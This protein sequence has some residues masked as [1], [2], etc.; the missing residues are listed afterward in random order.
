MDRPTERRSELR[1]KTN[2]PI[3]FR[4][5]H[6]LEYYRAKELNHSND[7]LSFSVDI[8]LKPGMS[9]NIRHEKCPENCPGGI[10]CDSCHGTIL[11]TVHWCHERNANGVTLYLAGAK[12][13]PFNIGY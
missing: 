3:I 9:V 4:T 1:Y 7:G 2:I 11:A 5:F 12:Y 6:A 13:F 8:K 10:A